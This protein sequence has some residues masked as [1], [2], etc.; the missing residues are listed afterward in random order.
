MSDLISTKPKLL[1]IGD[2]L[3]DVYLTGT[4]N[5]RNGVRRFKPTSRDVHCGGAANTEQNAMAILDN[6]EAI[7]HSWMNDWSLPLY[8]LIDG[9]TTTEAYFDLVSEDCLYLPDRD[10]KSSYDGIIISDYNKGTVNKP[11]KDLSYI[12]QAPWV[13]VDSRYRSVHPDFINLG[14]IKIWRCTGD[15]FNET[16]AK[17]FSFV[18]HTDGANSVRIYHTFTDSYSEKRV[19]CITPVDVCGAG[20]TFTAAIASY[21]LL[22]AMKFKERPAWPFYCSLKEA[23]PFAIRAAQDVCMKPRTAIT[24]VRL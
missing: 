15:E 17:Q 6:Q 16:W 24:S 13:I 23:I 22:E 1:V 3:K 10:W 11:H 20:D 21:L 5:D 19:P 12:E 9:D 8:R 18:I 2:A 7:I 4:W 14:K